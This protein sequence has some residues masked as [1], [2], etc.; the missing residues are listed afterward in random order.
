M[1]DIYEKGGTCVTQFLPKLRK[2]SK[3]KLG[4]CPCMGVSPESHRTEPS[5]NAPEIP[6][7]GEFLQALYL[8]F[9]V[10]LKSEGKSTYHN[11]SILR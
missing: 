8:R 1:S 4:K 11:I 5:P 10:N 3:K 6:C 7:A 2:E 9:I